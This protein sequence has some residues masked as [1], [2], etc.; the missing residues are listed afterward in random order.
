MAVTRG[1]LLVDAARRRG[2]A[3]EEAAVPDEGRGG[4]TARRIVPD[5]GEARGLGIGVGKVCDGL[6][7]QTAGAAGSRDM[8]ES[9]HI[10]N[11]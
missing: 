10:G 11:K 6:G 4:G 9:I 1:G 3:V 7:G 8:Y 2:E 5:T